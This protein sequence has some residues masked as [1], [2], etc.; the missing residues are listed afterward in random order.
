[1][2]TLALGVSVKIVLNYFFVSNPAINIFGAPISSLVCYLIS[3]VPNVYYVNKY[4]AMKFDTMN[5]LLR[6]GL[7]SIGMAIVLYLLQ[8][9]LPF[10]RLSTLV[11]FFIGVAV[12]FVLAVLCKALTKEDWNLIRNRKK[13]HV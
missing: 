12:F 2:Y 7:A 13:K 9:V 10:G 8:K 1:M 4:C 3:T 11:L 5:Y 6:P